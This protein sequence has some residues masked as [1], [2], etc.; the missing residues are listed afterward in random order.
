MADPMHC[1]QDPPAPLNTEE[2]GAP[3]PASLDNRRDC[4][5]ATGSQ[6]RLLHHSL[7][8]LM[9]PGESRMVIYLKTKKMVQ[10]DNHLAKTE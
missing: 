6:D 4:G 9:A 8:W 5:P 10:K 7:G 3:V 1:F 2:A